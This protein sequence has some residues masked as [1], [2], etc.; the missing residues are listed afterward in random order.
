[1]SERVEFRYDPNTKEG[2]AIKVWLEDQANVSGAIRSL[3]VQAV[4]GDD[5]LARRAIRETVEAAVR[6]AIRDALGNAQSGREGPSFTQPFD[7]ENPVL[8]AKIDDLFT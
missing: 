5:T 1:M 8:A 2:Q 7:F 6:D 3:I 4:Q